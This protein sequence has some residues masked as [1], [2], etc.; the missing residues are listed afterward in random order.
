MGDSFSVAGDTHYH[1]QQSSMPQ[2]PAKASTL[3]KA[4]LVAAGLMGGAGIGA[5][6][7]LLLGASDSTNTTIRETQELGVGVDVVPGGATE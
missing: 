2:S 6:V 7:P 1:Y 3:A 5:A 4:A